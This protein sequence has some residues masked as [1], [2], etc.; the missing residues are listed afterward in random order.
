LCKPARDLPEACLA[1]AALPIA[2][3]L[4]QMSGK[5]AAQPARF[6]EQAEC[7]VIRNTS[8]LILGTRHQQTENDVYWQAAR[9][10]LSFLI[11]CQQRTLNSD[12]VDFH[13]G[14]LRRAA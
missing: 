5:L 2:A 14:I 12:Y 9:T 1:A 13:Q 11:L 6:F 7:T 4:S 8:S 3:L 10:R